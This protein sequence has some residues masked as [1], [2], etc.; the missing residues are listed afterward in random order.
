M[1]ALLSSRQRGVATRMVRTWKTVVRVC[2]WI[3]LGL[4]A[5]CAGGPSANLAES[6]GPAPGPMVIARGADPGTGP[7]EESLLTLS[8][9]EF[10]GADN[11]PLLL[12]QILTEEDLERAGFR[13][14]TLNETVV[15]G[16]ITKTSLL[17]IFFR[18]DLRQQQRGVVCAEKLPGRQRQQRFL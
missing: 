16:Q 10:L 14:L 11:P 1:P 17:E 9:R 4:W 18:Q 3:G 5:G 7:S 12:P 2:S 13:D 6:P 8:P 15:Q